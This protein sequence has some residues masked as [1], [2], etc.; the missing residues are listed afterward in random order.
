[1]KVATKEWSIAEKILTPA[2]GI[3]PGPPGSKSSALTTE[4]KS[5]YPDAVV[6][7]ENKSIQIYRKL[8]HHKIK[9]FK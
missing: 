6:H 7:Y 3:E 9:V 2:V 5:R 4:P 1:M 8:Y